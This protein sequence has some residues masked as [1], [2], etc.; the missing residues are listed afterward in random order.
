MAS[1]FQSRVLPRIALQ[2]C[3]GLA[4]MASIPAV[5]AA[6]FELPPLAQPPTS[7]HHVGK[8][9]W[10]DLVTPDL[11]GAKRF[12]GGLFGWQFR[13]V[14][15]AGKDYSVAFLEERPVAGLVQR[16][17]RNGEQRQPAW[18][19][20]IAVKDAD[21]AE[22][23]AIA[24]G[25]KALSPARTY[26]H[27][28]RQAV[29]ADPQGAVFAV[30]ASASGDPPDYLAA[31]GDWIWSSLQTA[32]AGT[33]AAFYQTL[34]NYEVF[35]ASSDDGR[36]HVVLSSDDFARASINTLSGDHRHPHWLNFVRVA[37]MNQAIAKV[38]SLGGRILVEPH[39]DNQGGNLALVADPAGAVFGL[40]EWSDTQSTQAGK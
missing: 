33:D 24:H 17:V 3:V 22:R 8:V 40:L 15:S 14:E 39:I 4:S 12:Y 37:D 28:G 31:P 35:D 30:L 18:L 11:D 5:R 2:M 1:D 6:H 20:F 7:E 34:F 21:A 27:R 38:T 19:T 26:P 32:D 23:M 13:D 36:E 9:I 10:A 25:A 16:T 29:L